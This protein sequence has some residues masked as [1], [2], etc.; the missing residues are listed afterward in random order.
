MLRLFHISTS[1]KT[2]KYVFNIETELNFSPEF[3]LK[4]MD[5]ICDKWESIFHYRPLYKFES[6]SFRTKI[7]I[8]ITSDS[9]KEIQSQLD[10]FLDDIWI[11]LHGKEGEN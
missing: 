5:E 10:K 4:K 2:D 7:R 9:M 11:S 3:F 8:I 1:E 6:L